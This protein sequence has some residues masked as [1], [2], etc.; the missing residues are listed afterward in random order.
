MNNYLFTFHHI[1][2][3]NKIFNLLF[4]QEIKKKCKI[5]EEGET[6][7]EEEEVI[8]I[9]VEEAIINFLEEIIKIHL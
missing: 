7:K 9:E 2:Q 3:F 1:Y 8:S 4:K 6:T 5:K